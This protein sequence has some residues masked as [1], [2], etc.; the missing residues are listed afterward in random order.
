MVK[1]ENG[2]GFDFV[3]RVTY[4]NENLRIAVRTT[5]DEILEP[6][7]AT[8]MMFEVLFIV[9]ILILIVISA[10]IY[11]LSL[12]RLTRLDRK[13][14]SIHSGNFDLVLE[15]NHNDEIGNLTNTIHV[16]LERIRS[17]TTQRIRHEK[18]ERKMQ[19]SL[20]VSAIDPHFIYNTLDTI[21]FLATMGKTDEIIASER[22]SHRYAE[23]QT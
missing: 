10:V 17:D 11:R 3:V 18:N 14:S 19:Y 22:R 2:D 9:L 1:N 13:M 20:M 5:E 12:K 21:T 6:Y 8:F 7:S 4:K 23:G 15:D 16:M